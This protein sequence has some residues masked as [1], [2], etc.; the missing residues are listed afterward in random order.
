LSDTCFSFIRSISVATPT[1]LQRAETAPRRR[2]HWKLDVILESGLSGNSPLVA[3]AVKAGIEI[4]L[5]ATWPGDRQLERRMHR[6]K[7]S[8]RRLCLICRAEPRRR[9]QSA[10]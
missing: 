4:Q 6:Y 3:A 2:G 5:A 8:P 9:R 10:D 7:N 1:S